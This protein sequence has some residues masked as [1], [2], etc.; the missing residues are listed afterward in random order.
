MKKY[1]KLLDFALIGGLGI[2]SLAAIA[3]ETLIMSTNIQM[4]LL[5]VVLV[6]VAGFLSLLW[7]E[8]PEDEREVYNQA[9]ASRAAYIVG[10]VVLMIAVLVES[11]N[12]VLDPALPIVLLAMVATKTLVQGH[13]DDK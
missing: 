1:R 10:A 11:I 3:P 2:M 12:H 7:R 9:S 8:N 13:K 4:V 6:L 5:G